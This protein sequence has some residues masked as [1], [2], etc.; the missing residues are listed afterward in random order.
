M[1]TRSIFTIFVAGLFTS[2]SWSQ[3]RKLAAWEEHWKAA[4]TN[5]DGKVTLREAQLAKWPRELVHKQNK[6]HDRVISKKEYRKI[7]KQIKKGIKRLGKKHFKL[8]DANKDKKISEREWWG[9]EKSFHKADLNKDGFISSDEA[10]RIHAAWLDRSK[11]AKQF[12]KLDTDKN[13]KITAKEWKDQK[14]TF[15]AM[16]KNGDGELSRKEF[17]RGAGKK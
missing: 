14:E 2:I 15:A 17:I 11:K 5:G 6:D 8:M 10:K 3:E 1:K 9:G 13:G 16:D 4:D 12:K 7:R